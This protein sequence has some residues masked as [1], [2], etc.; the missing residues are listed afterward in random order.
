MDT[1]TLNLRRHTVHRYAEFARAISKRTM[2]GVLPKVLYYGLLTEK[3]KDIAATIES[4]VFQ[5][6]SLELVCDSLFFCDEAV[7]TSFVQFVF[8]DEAGFTSSFVETFCLRYWDNLPTSPAKT[9]T[10]T[11]QVVNVTGLQLVSC[12][13]RGQAGWPERVMEKFPEQ[14]R[15]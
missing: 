5:C 13:R 10:R 4:E 1:S 2:E 15:Y 14:P 8:C 9:R 11:E 6:L 3:Q 12:T 7:F